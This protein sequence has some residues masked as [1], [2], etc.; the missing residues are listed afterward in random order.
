MAP[1]YANL[2]MSKL[3]ESLFS[4]QPLLNQ[5]WWRYIDDVFAI[6]SHGEA[7]LNGDLNATHTTIKFSANW[8]NDSVSFL[9]T[10]V[11]LKDGTLSTD[12]YTRSTDTHQY[13]AAG[14][15]HRYHCKSAIPYSRAVSV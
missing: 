3:E 11:I 2:F 7:T 13:L 4:C 5:M 10:L 15:C 9:D 8:S 14:S 1:S 12:L 6:W